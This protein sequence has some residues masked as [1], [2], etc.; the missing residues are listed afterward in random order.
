MKS[1]YPFTF[2]PIFKERVWG[3]RNLERLYGKELPPGIPVGESWE[4]ADRPGDASLIAN[5]DLAGRD[6]RWLM[7]ERGSEII[8]AARSC[9]GRFPLLVKILD[10]QDVLSLQVHPPA[11]KAASLGGEPKTEMWFFAECA[12]GAGI[13]A[14][15]KR[16]TTRAEFE[17]RI[18]D[19]T[20][21]ECFHY[22]PVKAGDAMLLPSG[23]V[24]ALGKGSVLFEIQQNSDTTYRV[25]D[26]NRVGLDGRPRA[27]HVPQSLAS[28]DFDDF[29]PA[30]IQTEYSRS[31]S[32]KVRYLV[33][34]PLFMI[35]A[36]RVRRGE[37]FHVRFQAPQVIGLLKGRLRLTHEGRDLELRAG[38]LGL[39]PAALERVTFTALTQADY[40]QAEPR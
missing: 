4:I 6:L 23:R 7:E 1:L 30:L 20:V 29:E 34:E 5:G 31:A 16:G 25:F 38:Q 33:D 17:R 10:A 24:H 21:A 15:L 12:A 36:C 13:Y 22:L 19:N 2:K 35:N 27:L 39:L 40:L 32:I 26:W 11:S 8:G 28:I 3:G 37:R 14:G 18:E 9:Q